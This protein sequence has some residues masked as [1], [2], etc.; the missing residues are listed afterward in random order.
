MASMKR[1]LNYDIE[2]ESTL[3]PHVTRQE[4]LEKLNDIS[5]K[6]KDIAKSNLR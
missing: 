4:C 5:R 1:R 6:I 2:N 3:L